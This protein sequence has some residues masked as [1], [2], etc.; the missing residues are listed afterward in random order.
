MQKLLGLLMILL[1]V[2]VVALTKEGTEGAAIV[3]FLGLIMI[4]DN[5]DEEYNYE[6]ENKEEEI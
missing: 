2:L 3:I 1:S 4:F 5:K 6:E